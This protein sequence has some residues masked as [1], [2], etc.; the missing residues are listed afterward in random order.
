MTLPQEYVDAELALLEAM[1]EL[2]SAAF[3]WARMDTS[4]KVSKQAHEVYDVAKKLELRHIEFEKQSTTKNI[5]KA[6]RDGE[7]L[8]RGLVASVSPSVLI[9][10]CSYLRKLDSSFAFEDAQAMRIWFM[11]REEVEQSETVS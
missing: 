4:E 1:K 3:L 5:S 9:S 8:G 10:L 6:I 2:Y 11:E 7:E